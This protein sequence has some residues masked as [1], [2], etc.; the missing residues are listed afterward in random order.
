MIKDYFLNPSF[1]SMIDAD[2]IEKIDLSSDDFKGARE[3]ALFYYNK[4]E[5][6]KSLPF[7]MIFISNANKVPFNIFQRARTSIGKLNMNKESVWREFSDF[8][9]IKADTV[10]DNFFTDS[11]KDIIKKFEIFSSI[12]IENSEIRN[13]WNQSFKNLYNS[14]NG[15]SSANIKL[16][17]SKKKIFVAGMGWSGSS[18]FYDFFKEFR[19]I[20]PVEGELSLFEGAGGLKDII[21]SIGD[22]NKLKYACLR[23]Y[24]LVLLG[25][26]PYRTSQ[27]YKS[28][29]FA[30]KLSC[31]DDFEQALDYAKRCNDFTAYFSILF[32]PKYGEPQHRL[33]IF[34]DQI[35]NFLVV[36]NSIDKKY[37]LF[38]N[39][40]H[41]SNL[42][43]IEYIPDSVVF[44]AFRDPRS[45]YIALKR[46]YAGFSST[47]EQFVRDTRN[48]LIRA[49]DILKKID[50]TLV[51]K[52]QFEEFVVSSV[53]RE[54]MANAC[55][56]T[57]HECDA[58]K[59]FKP[60]ESFKNTQLY[61]DYENQKD[62][63]YIH[64]E[65]KE[66]CMRFE[67]ISDSQ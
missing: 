65:M 41:I 59:Y 51:K 1:M 67:V 45:L 55:G 7:F 35:V 31:S 17:T 14:L 2:D 27:C 39:C 28:M 42:E 19:E 18:A 64:R 22:T 15:C 24:F 25:F 23:F 30:R 9:S 8:K 36:P 46:E 66:H 54:K 43:L 48:Q 40:I 38:D 62:I 52:I 57:M 11:K 34:A 21:K 12:I 47:C 33:R 10:I 3:L 5:Y 6:E 50:S 49:D 16:P 20:Y 44:A 29:L 4:K 32:D 56:L 26:M 61:L 37:L 60:W 58:F 13:I 63:K 53:C